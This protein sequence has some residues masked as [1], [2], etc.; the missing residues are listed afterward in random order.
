MPDDLYKDI[1]VSL[2]HAVICTLALTFIPILCNVI[3]TPV[4]KKY[5]D[6][7]GKNNET[8]TPVKNLDPYPSHHSSE[9]LNNLKKP[10]KIQEK[11]VNF[12]NYY[13]IGT[14][15]NMRVGS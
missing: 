12:G 8:M 15:G 13:N 1:R 3:I 5:K 2:S 10:E 9:A 7:K 11:N 4:M 6:L 14:L